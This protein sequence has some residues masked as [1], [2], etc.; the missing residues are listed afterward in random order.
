MEKMFYYCTSL[1][2]LNLKSFTEEKLNNIDEM[3]SGIGKN[4]T[5]CINITKAPNITK[6]IKTKSSNN[7]CS[8]TCFLQTAILLFDK[9]K[10]IS[11]YEQNTSFT[12]KYNNECVKSCPKRARISLYNNF[13]CEDLNCQKYYNY[14]QTDCLEEI[15]KGYFLNDSYLKT[16]DKCNYNYSGKCFWECINDTNNK[17][18]CKELLGQNNIEYLTL[19]F[20]KD[21]CIYCYNGTGHYPFYN[22]SILNSDTFTDCYKELEGYFLDNDKAYKPC[23]NTCKT[24]LKEGNETNNN[25]L[26]C[27]DN[28]RFLN[29]TKSNVNNC[30]ETCDEN[31]YYF[32][33]FNKYQCTQK[34]ECPNGY[35]LIQEK[36]KCI[37]NCS[38]DHEYL[39]EF[40]NSC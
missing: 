4:L 12:Y 29:D 27:K 6:A 17:Y 1:I 16:I 25:C 11:C 40:N 8:N 23:F 14:N 21:L 35:K 36:N 28:Y 3:F 24:C 30:Y 37:D 19:C 39:Y 10:C 34:K 33:S 15:P 2:Y 13:L 38:K 5:Y 32:D 18:K 9:K 31:Y 7:K 26:E 20:K 22:Q